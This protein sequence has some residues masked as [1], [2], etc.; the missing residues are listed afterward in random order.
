MNNENKNN[1][2][3]E[4][5]GATV[6]A[7]AKEDLF[8]L[9]DSNANTNVA[10]TSIEDTC[11]YCCDGCVYPNNTCMETAKEISDESYT[12]GYICSACV[13]QW[14]KFTATKNGKYT[15]CTYSSKDTV[16]TLYDNNG[17]F[18]KKLDNGPCGKDFRMVCAFNEG[19]TYYIKVEIANGDTGNYA[20]KVTDEILVNTVSINKDTIRLVKGITYELPLSPYYKYKGYKGAQPIPELSVSINPANAN[21]KEIWWYEEPNGILQ[22][23]CD[24]DDDGDKYIHI[25]GKEMGESKLYGIDRKENGKRGECNVYSSPKVTVISCSPDGWLKSSEIMGINMAKAFN[26]EG[27]YAVKIPDN[28]LS[29]ETCWNAVEECVIIHTHGSP[30]GLF[31]EIEK[32][33][34]IIVSKENIANLPINNSIYFVMMTSCSTAGGATDDNVAYWLSKKIN[35]D[36]IVIANTDR[37]SGASTKFYG[38]NETPTWR[39]YKNGIIQDPIPD[40][41]L[42]MENAYNIYQSYK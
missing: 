41:V 4:N 22:F 9:E 20:L 23:E 35:P 29:F 18:I 11:T 34:P 3:I 17:T 14:F 7:L 36:G 40:I 39:I 33:T 5:D 2:F 31:N 10:I 28:Y 42:N 1:L 27:S 15:I 16:G 38:S 21:A 37:V 13:A 25:A 8:V 30:D 6:D 26:Y 12:E 24:W 19:E 32:S